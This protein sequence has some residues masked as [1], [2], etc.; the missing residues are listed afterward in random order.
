MDGQEGKAAQAGHSTAR[1]AGRFADALGARTLVLTHFS[2]R[3][4]ARGGG[5]VGDI[6]AGRQGGDIDDRD[7]K[8]LQ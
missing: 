6:K 2:P 8:N 7:V 5:G 4:V 3:F 1:M